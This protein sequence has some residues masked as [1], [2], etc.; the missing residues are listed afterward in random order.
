MIL[1]SEIAA[2]PARLLLRV[3]VPDELVSAMTADVLVCTH[4]VVGSTDDDD[5]RAGGVELPGEVAADP[6][7]LLDPTDVQPRAPKDGLALELVV[8]R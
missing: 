3:V 1:A 8:L 7:N 6:A 4:P 5:R 2:G